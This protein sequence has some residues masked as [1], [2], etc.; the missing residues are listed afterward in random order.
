MRAKTLLLMSLALSCATSP[1][2]RRQLEFLPDEQ[3]EKMGTEAFNQLKWNT[4]QTGDPVQDEAVQCVVEEL[5]IAA[6]RMHAQHLPKRW[7][8]V[9]LEDPTPNAFALPGGK[10]GVNQGL[11]RVAKTPGQ[12]AAVLGH[13]MSH[14]IAGHGNERMSTALPAQTAEQIVQAIAVPN[15]PAQHQTRQTAIAL[16]GAGAEVG[17]VLPFSRA[18][19]SEAD[20]YGLQIMANAGFDPREAIDLWKSFESLG[21]QQPLQFLSDHP[22]EGT[23][24][25][26]LEKRLPRAEAEYDGAIASGAGPSCPFR[27]S[28]ALPMRDESARSITER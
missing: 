15:D 23:R 12:L 13:E 2:G 8:V 27:P 10:I 3:V 16:L 7:E 19:E 4:P 21:G 22:A 25:Q 28:A 1:T 5:S 14:V 24:I 17:V 6:A 20:D 18:Q 26:D 11:F 9:V